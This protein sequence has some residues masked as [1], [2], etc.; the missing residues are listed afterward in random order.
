MGLSQPENF[1]NPSRAQAELN[2]P[3]LGQQ[4]QQL[5]MF[6]T[7]QE[8]MSSRRP[9]LGE[10]GKVYPQ[11]QPSRVETDTD[12]MARKTADLDKPDYEGLRESVVTEGVKNPIHLTDTDIGEGHH[13][14]AALME[15]D[16][17]RYVPVMHHLSMDQLGSYALDHDEVI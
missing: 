13:R 14:L 7:A 10:R 2:A 16:P 8:I 11:G 1:K 15:Q 17:G 4:W 6:M 12:M 3:H 9:A 5:P